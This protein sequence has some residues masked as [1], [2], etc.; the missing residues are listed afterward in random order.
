VSTTTLIGVTARIEMRVFDG[1]GGDA[2]SA[3]AGRGCAEELQPAA[4]AVCCG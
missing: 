2:P 1:D 4:S 3:A